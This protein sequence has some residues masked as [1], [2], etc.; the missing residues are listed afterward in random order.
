MYFVDFEK[1][2]F[3]RTGNYRTKELSLSLAA[4]DTVIQVKE[5]TREALEYFFEETNIETLF[6][7]SLDN[8]VFE[9][10]EE[11]DIFFT[12]AVNI[13][14]AI[15]LDSICLKKPRARERR[16]D[17]PVKLKELASSLSLIKHLVNMTSYYDRFNLMIHWTAEIN[18]VEHEYHYTLVPQG[19]NE[20]DN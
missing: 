9:D 1:L 3:N 11:A 8:I 13:I 15:F 2:K 17:V 4:S 14:S 20:N 19:E 7:I 16:L 10:L 6:D 12:Y 18:G 5:K